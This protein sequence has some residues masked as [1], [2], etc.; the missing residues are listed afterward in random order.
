MLGRYLGGLLALIY[1][2]SFLFFCV[3]VTIQF[4]IIISTSFKPESPPFVWHLVVLVPALYVSYL[5]ISVPARM[6]E[7]LLPLGLLL[8]PLV[9]LLN[10]PNINWDEYLPM[11]QHGL[12]PPIEGAV[13]TAGELTYPMLILALIPLIS[14]KEKLVG[15]GIPALLLLA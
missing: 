15:Y 8:L 5:G 9:A 13:L 10:I 14:H 2:V 4:S 12:L 7:L 3:M 6:N 1:I 11:L